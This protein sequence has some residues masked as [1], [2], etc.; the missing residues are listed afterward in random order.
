MTKDPTVSPSRL[1]KI[2]AM[3][4][5]PSMAPPKRMVMPLPMPEIS[6]P[7]R[8]HSSRS[9]PAKGD[10]EETSTGRMLVMTK[11]AEE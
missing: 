3:T 2:T 4:S 10:A 8:A 7:N 1:E 9:C 6:P 5:M 11:E